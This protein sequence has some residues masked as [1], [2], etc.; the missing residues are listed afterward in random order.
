MQQQ[1]TQTWRA[2][3]GKKK[4]QTQPGHGNARSARTK[5]CN[6]WCRKQY[7]CVVLCMLCR[8]RVS[9]DHPVP[10]AEFTT[11]EVKTAFLHAPLSKPAYC[12]IAG[13]TY[14]LKKAL[15]GLP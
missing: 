11:L 1:S 15:C 4:V 14:R 5:Q 12:R 2:M 3:Q 7:V 9:V 6:V 8:P 13:K 10:T